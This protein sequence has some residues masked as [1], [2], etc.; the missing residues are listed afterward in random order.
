[1]LPAT[2]LAVVVLLASLIA[3]PAPALAAIGRRSPRGDAAVV[4]TGARR[5]RSRSLLLSR[6]GQV[7]TL[8]ALLGWAAVAVQAMS[9]QPVPGALLRVLQVLQLLGVVAIVPAVIAAVQAVRERRGALAVAG[10]VLVV[11]ALVV[12]AWVAVAYRLLAPSVSF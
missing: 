11:V 9:Y 7:A 12:L 2:V 10:R 6:L 4:P 3:W 1:V 5:R 8:V